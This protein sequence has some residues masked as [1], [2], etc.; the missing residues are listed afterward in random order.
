M[1]SNQDGLTNMNTLTLITALTLFMSSTT[2]FADESFK[3]KTLVVDPA[4][5]TRDY[6]HPEGVAEVRRKLSNQK[7]N[8]TEVQS[9]LKASRL[10]EE[11]KAWNSK[12]IEELVRKSGEYPVDRLTGLYPKLS[13]ESLSSLRS[14]VL[15]VRAQKA[16]K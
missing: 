11:V 12:A 15:G 3:P 4:L 2:S 8:K 6:E 7:L 1:V 14:A 9:V 5:S 16:K 13:R 10:T